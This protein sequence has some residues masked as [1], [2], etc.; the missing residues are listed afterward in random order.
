VCELNDGDARAV[1][2]TTNMDLR[3]YK[4]MKLFT[5]AENFPGDKGSLYPIKD[6]DLT[7]FMRIGSDFTDNYYEYEIPLKVTP[8]GNYNPE[9]EMDKR[10]IWP[11][12]NQIMYCI[13]FA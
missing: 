1:F 10:L 11:D 6:N 13:G 3:N 9:S 5:H 12:S 7:V 2:K 4:R 8:A